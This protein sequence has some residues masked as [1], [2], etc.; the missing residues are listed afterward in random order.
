MT[1][2]ITRPRAADIR[3]DIS[4]GCAALDNDWRFT[5]LNAAAARI[6]GRSASDLL[7]RTLFDALG[8]DPDNPFLARYVASKASGEP[9]VFTAYSEVFRMWL[10]VRG[11]PRPDGYTIFFRDVTAERGG[12]GTAAGCSVRCARAR[13]GLPVTQVTERRRGRE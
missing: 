4:D 8:N 9:A 13:C 1:H 2:S 5:Y 12:F 11:Y 7:G 6:A 10:E 3:A